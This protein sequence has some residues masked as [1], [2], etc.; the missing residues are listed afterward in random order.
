MIVVEQITRTPARLHPM[1]ERKWFAAVVECR[2]SGSAGQLFAIE[3]CS[4]RCS[5]ED[6]GEGET[7]K[8]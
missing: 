4:N 6:Q 2:E 7:Y 1:G 8:V 5:G 3:K